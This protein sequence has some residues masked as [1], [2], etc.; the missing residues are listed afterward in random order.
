MP[1]AQ[2][3]TKDV[4]LHG[5]AGCARNASRNPKRKRI[6]RNRGISVDSGA[7][8]RLRRVYCPGESHPDLPAR[9][10]DETLARLDRF[11]N[12]KGKTPTA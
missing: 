8:Q 5:P 2:E 3:R 10:G 9:A 4:V 7:A 1:Q 6:W 12:A 11:R